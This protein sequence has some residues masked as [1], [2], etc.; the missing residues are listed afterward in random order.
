[1]QW[2]CPEWS[3]WE[4]ET[5][6]YRVH[7]SCCAAYHAH[8]VMVLNVALPGLAAMCWPLEGQP[9]NAGNQG[10]VVA[11]GVNGTWQVQM[12]RNMWY[13]TNDTLHRIFF[14]IIFLIIIIKFCFIV[15]V[16]LSAHVE[17]FIVC[18]MRDFGVCSLNYRT[19]RLYQP[20]YCQTQEGPAM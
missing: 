2:L 6:A 11:D 9:V 18:C 19:Y 3:V 14:V 20:H 15:F 16:L 5:V 13:L 1:M 10:S 4:G 17:R 8:A 12:T 7:T